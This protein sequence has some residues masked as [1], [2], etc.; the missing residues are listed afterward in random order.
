M[1][2]MLNGTID[3]E[4]GSITNNSVRAKEV[5][6]AVITYMEEGRISVKAKSGI[7]AVKDLDG[8][9]V[10]TT[11][12]TTS[13]QNLRKVA[14]ANGISF[15]DIYGKD[16]QDSFLLLESG[17][18]DAFVMDGSILAGIISKSKNPDDFTIVGEPLS[19]EPIACMSRKG[20][21]EFKDAIDESIKRLIAVGSLA[22]WL[23]C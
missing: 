2:L 12:G 7:T 5:S 3:L 23:V 16:H 10:A 13:V 22:R 9:I 6:F 21:P 1:P 20:D 18:T 17:R 11:T 8:K 4:C 15:T 14:R 19:V